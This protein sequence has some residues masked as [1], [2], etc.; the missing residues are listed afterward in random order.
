MLKFFEIPFSK[1]KPKIFQKFFREIFSRQSTAKCF[2]KSLGQKLAILEHLEY[3]QSS[4][5]N[6]QDTTNF[7]IALKNTVISKMSKN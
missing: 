2:S 4:S 1:I 5:L 6:N 7:E 3:V